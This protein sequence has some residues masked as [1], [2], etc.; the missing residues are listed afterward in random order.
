MKIAMNIKHLVIIPFIVLTY[1]PQTYAEK[2]SIKVMLNSDV[3]DLV[4]KYEESDATSYKD[5]DHFYLVMKYLN[6]PNLNFVEVKS[7]KKEVDFANPQSLLP[8]RNAKRILAE[9][10]R[11]NP[12]L[13]K[14]RPISQK[15]NLNRRELNFKAVEK[16]K[17]D[18][19]YNYFLGKIK[20]SSTPSIR[21]CLNID[22]V[23]LGLFGPPSALVPI[24]EIDLRIKSEVSN[25]FSS[26][27][28]DN[29]NFHLSI[30]DPSYSCHALVNVDKQLLNQLYKNDMVASFMPPERSPINYFTAN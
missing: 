5:F 25:L 8:Y 1:S 6:Y 9:K 23:K 29:E 28:Y 22:I 10:E 7:H 12:S 14:D 30:L 21:I 26:L 11:I 18:G 19:Y 27:D 13:K 4:A 20:S 2:E 17:K 24:E 3:Y 16:F 15:E